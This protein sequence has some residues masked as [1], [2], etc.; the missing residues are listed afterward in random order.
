[1]ESVMCRNLEMSREVDRKG[2][3]YGLFGLKVHAK[4][5]IPIPPVMNRYEEPAPIS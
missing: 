2:L 3:K 4:H 5:I 1:M